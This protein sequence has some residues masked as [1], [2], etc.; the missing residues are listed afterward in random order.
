MTIFDLLL[1]HHLCVIARLDVSHCSV[2]YSILRV[3]FN[4]KLHKIV[5]FI[6][7]FLLDVFFLH[8]SM[9]L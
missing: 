6:Q 4:E 9:V 5:Y 8:F 7:T 3:F 1:K 2:L